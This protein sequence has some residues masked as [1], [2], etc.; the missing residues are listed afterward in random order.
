MLF[1]HLGI[2]VSISLYFNQSDILMGHTHASHY[3]SLFSFQ[4]LHVRYPSPPFDVL[5]HIPSNVP[6]IY[7]TGKAHFDHY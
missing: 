1:Y 7:Y 5:E 6:L 4:W 2:P 3:F